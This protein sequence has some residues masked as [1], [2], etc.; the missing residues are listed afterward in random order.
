M[1]GTPDQ[2]SQQIL[3]QLA[4]TM[5]TLSC[6]IGTP[7]RKIIDACAE[8]IAAASID[9]YLLGSLLDVDTKAGMELE[10]FVGLFG[11][12]RLQ[13][14][15]AQGTVRVTLTVASTTDYTIQQGTTFYTTAGLAGASVQL[16]Y[17]ANQSVVLPAGD[18]SVDVPVTCTT[19]GVSGNVPPG[20]VTNLSTA[21]GSSAVTNL[22]AMTDGTDPETDDALRQRFKDTFLR[23]VAGT[24]DWYIALCQQNTSVTR[25]IVFGPTALHHADRRALDDGS[26][27][28]RP[29]RQVRMVPHPRDTS[30][31]RR[32]GLGARG[33]SSGWRS[34]RRVRRVCR[35]ARQ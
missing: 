20:A 4:L 11:Y 23:N 17:A 25:V 13:G 10:Q 2:I 24:A 7:E 15:Y 3:A 30:P 16:Y 27:A 19:V 14:T 35:G 34:D 31:Y 8:Q 21:I 9:T 12:G 26:A 6:A 28:G 22:Q 29:G 33:L 1:P 32:P 18:Y 5:P